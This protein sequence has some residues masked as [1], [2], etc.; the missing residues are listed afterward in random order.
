[1]GLGEKGA[2]KCSFVRRAPHRLRAQSLPDAAARQL[3]ADVGYDRA[4]GRERKTQHRLGSALG[5]RYDAGPLRR[6]VIAM[7]LRPQSVPSYSAGGCSVSAGSAAGS[8]ASIQPARTRA[9]RIIASACAR[10]TP[11]L[12][13]KPGF[14]VSPP[15]PRSVQPTRSSLAQSARSSSDLTPFSP[16]LT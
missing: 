8:G 7:S 2:R 4:V 1:L 6:A 9:S 5:A 16:S 11:K 13:R 15:S 10:V 12:L 3:A 14:A